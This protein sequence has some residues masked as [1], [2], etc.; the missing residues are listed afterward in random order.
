MTHPAEMTAIE[1][2]GPGTPDVLK[3]ARRKVPEPG[4]GEVLIEVLAAGIN[5]PDVSQR[6]GLYP[7]PPGASDI[8]GLEIAGRVVASG[9]EQGS[10]SPGDM[11]CALVAGGGYAEYCVAPADQ[12]L[13]VPRG[14][15][16]LEAAAIPETFFTV[17]TNLFDR[18]GFKPGETLL[19]HG[20]SSGIGTTAIQLAHAF[21]GT[22]YT[23]AGNDE[24]C[25][26]CLALGADHAV[27]YRTQDFVETILT[28]TEKRGVDVVIDMVGGDYIPRNIRC[29]AQDGRMVFLAFLSGSTAEVNFMPVLRKRLMITGSTLRPR[30]VAEKAVIARSLRTHVWPLFEAGAVRPVLYQSYRLDEASKAHALMEASS[31]IGKIMLVTRAGENA[32]L[33]LGRIGSDSITR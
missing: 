19:L 22:V 6:A 31:H 25:A 14:F 27:N 12:C 11:V 29:M 1:I 5:R 8:P 28:L 23:T 33:P 2:T 24:K 7:P 15:S 17:W 16:V 10:L 26:A 13:P 32:G 9:P 4:P 20:G 21:G 18:A 30:S 3:P